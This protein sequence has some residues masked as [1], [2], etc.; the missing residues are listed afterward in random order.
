MVCEIIWLSHRIYSI[1]RDST[2]ECETNDK[3][4]LNKLKA[5]IMFIKSKKILLILHCLKF[6]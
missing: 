5:N 3:Y 6:V 4:K 1:E 2:N